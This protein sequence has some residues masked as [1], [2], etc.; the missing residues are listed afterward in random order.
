MDFMPYEQPERVEYAVTAA[1]ETTAEMNEEEEDRA[2]DI[3]MSRARKME[4]E[5]T[6]R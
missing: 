2:L 3:G 4:H 6:A 1:N 5:E